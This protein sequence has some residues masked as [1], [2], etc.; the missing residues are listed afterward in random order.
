MLSDTL[1]SPKSSLTPAI[2]RHAM[3]LHTP[4]VSDNELRIHVARSRHIIL[5]EEAQAP[6][7]LGFARGPVQASARICAPFGDRLAL[8]MA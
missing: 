3:G 4:V 6:R 2:I 7:S 1:N 5:A 8:G